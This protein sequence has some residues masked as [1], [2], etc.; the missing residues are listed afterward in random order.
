MFTLLS[1]IK[2][3]LNYRAY[4]VALLT[5]IFI[6]PHIY[7]QFANDFP[8]ISYHLADRA[9]P[10]YKIGQTLDY[11]A[12]NLPFL[13]GL[14]SVALFIAAAFYK[15][16]DKWEK[17]LK[18]N[19][20]GM[21]IFFLLIT[22]K[23]Q[24]IEANWTLLCVFPMLYLGYKQVELSKYFTAYKYLTF[25]F[26]ALLLIIRFHIVSPLAVIKKDRIWDF[27][28]GKQFAQS[29]KNIAGERK[30][31]TNRYQDASVLNFYLDE[32][33]YITALNIG[34]RANQYSIWKLDTVLCHQKVAFVNR[35]F[36]GVKIKARTFLTA[37]VALR[38]SISTPNCGGKARIK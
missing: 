14:V 38:D 28:D 24:Y 7:W 4:I 1:N 33:Y 20:F 36:E 9:A 30:I 29:V 35:K 6:S 23:G 8:S 27:Y 17:A 16:A 37:K 19:L 18:W 22:F 25:F 2:L 32:D 31:T 5:L 10:K 15:P 12:G 26:A 3:F 13:G 11:L 21:Y 34:S